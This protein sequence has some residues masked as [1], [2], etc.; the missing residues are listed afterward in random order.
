MKLSN[1]DA[2]I[3]TQKG[4]DLIITLKQENDS[5]ETDNSTEIS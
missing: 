5:E 1:P 3:V 4:K 2:F